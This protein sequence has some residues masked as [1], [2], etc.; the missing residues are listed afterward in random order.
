M[1]KLHICRFCG[2]P[3][4][5]SP[6]TILPLF[7][8]TPVLGFVGCSSGYMGGKWKT[9]KCYAKLVGTDEEYE[10][11]VEDWNKENPHKSFSEWMTSTLYVTR[12]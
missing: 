8:G 12:N 1:S 5:D 2:S 7:N 4:T 11:A 10:K 3:A 9:S 6:P